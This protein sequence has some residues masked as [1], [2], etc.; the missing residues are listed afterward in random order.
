MKYEKV[1]RFFLLNAFVSAPTPLQLPSLSYDNFRGTYAIFTIRSSFV[2]SG[3]PPL[4]Q[5]RDFCVSRNAF[6]VSAGCHNLFEADAFVWQGH[7]TAFTCA[8]LRIVSGDL[9]GGSRFCRRYRHCCAE[10]Y[11]WILIILKFGSDW[12]LFFGGRPK[13]SSVYRNHRGIADSRTSRTA[14]ESRF[15]LLWEST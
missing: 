4:R 7:V 1:I 5:Q 8:S 15:V 6:A 11:Q 2:W 9:L 3:G 13:I 12:E 10:E 14:C